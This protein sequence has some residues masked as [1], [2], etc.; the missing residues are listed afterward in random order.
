MFLWSHAARKPSKKSGYLLSASWLADVSARRRA[1]ERRPTVET[2]K[3]REV[4]ELQMFRTFHEVR[5]IEAGDVIPDYHIRVDLLKE[6]GPFQ[7]QFRLILVRDDLGASDIGASVERENI[8]DERFRFACASR[9]SIPNCNNGISSAITLSSYH[10][11]NLDD[12]IFVGLWEDTLSTCTL[13]V[14][15]EYPERCDP[16]PFALGRVR[17]EL[18]PSII[19]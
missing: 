19:P 4:N 2:T 6:L 12:R 3:E 13:D 7:Q 9:G 14:E 18:V 17:Y 11:G 10:V 5:Q 8:P 15:T 1:V 16:R